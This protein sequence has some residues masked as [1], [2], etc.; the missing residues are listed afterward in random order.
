V[1]RVER[2]IVEMHIESWAWAAEGIIPEGRVLRDIRLMDRVLV[3]T[4]DYGVE[5]ENWCVVMRFANGS[6]ARY[7][8]KA[9]VPNRGEGQFAVKDV[10]ACRNP[11]DSMKWDGRHG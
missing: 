10:I 1:T 9:E 11:D 8:I 6:A 5:G 7:P 2:L 3:D 4:S